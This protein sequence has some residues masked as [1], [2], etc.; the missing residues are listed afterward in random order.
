MIFVAT[1]AIGVAAGLTRSVLSVVV[2]CLAVIATFV[3]AA[4]TGGGASFLALLTAVGGYNF[5]LILL[6]A[7]Q[8]IAAKP[9]MKQA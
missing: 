5:G 3:A 2:A 8:Y 1:F 6:V 4:V 9:E 7:A